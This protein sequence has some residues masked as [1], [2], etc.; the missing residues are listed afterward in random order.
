[1]TRP[2][3]SSAEPRS[4]LPR[5]RELAGRAS[6]DR[7]PRAL[8]SWRSLRAT[9]GPVDPLGYGSLWVARE[10]RP[11]QSAKKRYSVAIRTPL[12]YV[13]TGAMIRSASNCFSHRH[14]WV[15]D[16]PSSGAAV[17]PLRWNR[18]PPL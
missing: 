13:L 8:A 15:S 7:P 18:S 11:P 9:E 4:P 14:A 1:M 16:T 3:G 6:A 10:V 5:A 2:G 12:G 17:R